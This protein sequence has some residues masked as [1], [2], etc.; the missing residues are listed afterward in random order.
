MLYNRVC[1]KNACVLA[2]S[3]HTHCAQDLLQQR[4]MRFEAGWPHA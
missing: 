1:Y 4:S 3:V 2:D